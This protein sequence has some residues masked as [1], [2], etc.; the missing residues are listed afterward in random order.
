MRIAIS[1]AQGTGKT[2]LINELRTRPELKDYTFVESIRGI[3]ELGFKL[4]DVGDDNAQLMV[5]AVHLKNYVWRNSVLD[6]CSLDALVYATHQYQT[7]K[8]TQETLRIAEAIFENLRYDLHF[9]IK[10]EFDLIDDDSRSMNQDYRNAIVQLYD[11]YIESYRINP[12]IVTGSVKERA[13]QII[14]N[15]VEYNVRIKE[16]DTIIE[17]LQQKLVESIENLNKQTT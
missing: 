16:E 9:Y 5:E 8:I 10:P 13:D 1:G 3:Q 15:V 4:N 12:I 7:E 14:K 11:D 6:R 17:M 2:S